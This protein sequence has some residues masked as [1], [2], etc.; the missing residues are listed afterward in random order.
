M[1]EERK[2]SIASSHLGLGE[3]LWSSG[4]LSWELESWQKVGHT[5]A[6]NTSHVPSR[7]GPCLFFGKHEDMWKKREKSPGQL[8]SVV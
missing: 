6:R 7:E 3:A 8:S 5:L 1:G 2:H 4:F